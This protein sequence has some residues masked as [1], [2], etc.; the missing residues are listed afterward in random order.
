MRRKGKKEI[1]KRINEKA[2]ELGLSNLS[3]LRVLKNIT[4]FLTFDEK[5]SE[6]AS[7]LIDIIGE[8]K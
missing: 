2:D 5:E 3:R 4:V 8:I 7:F 6:F 1:A